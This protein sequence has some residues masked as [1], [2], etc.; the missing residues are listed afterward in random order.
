[1]ESPPPPAIAALRVGFL[2]TA[3][4]GRKNASALRRGGGVPALVASRSLATATAFASTWGFDAAVGSY[5][6]ALADASL[7]AVYLPLPTALRSGWALAAAAA[8]KAVMLEKPCAG[9]LAE[10]RAVAAACAAAGVQ[11]MDGTMFVH[12]ARTHA[13]AAALAEG[14]VGSPRVVTSTFGFAGDTEFLGNDIRVDPALEPAGVLG[15]LT[16]YCIRVALLAFGYAPPSHAACDVHR[17]SAKGVPVEA[18]TTLYWPD[19]RRGVFFNSFCVAF[20]QR[21]D[22]LGDRGTLHCDDYVLPRDSAAFT[23]VEA[24]GLRDAD[25]VVNM[26]PCVVR[27]EAGPGHQEEEMWRAF[28]GLVCGGPAAR[29]R[30]WPRVALLTQAALDAAL[31]S[32]N[33]GGARVAVEDIGEDY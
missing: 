6:E 8:G 19:G 17:R 14:R 24:P 11:L 33:S 28:C 3:K 13:L 31:A 1:M 23:I 18:T 2:S 10:L 22:V 7:D 26:V 29:E 16:W 9:S 5:E 15:D 25:R 12:H 21:L 32:A 30:S 4:I 20:V 27:H